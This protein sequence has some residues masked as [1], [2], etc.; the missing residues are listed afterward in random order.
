MTVPRI[1]LMLLTCVVAALACGGPGP[2]SS[3]EPGDQVECG[4]DL[5]CLQETSADCTPSVVIHSSEDILAGMD[6]SIETRITITGEEDGRCLVTIQTVSA[7]LEYTADRLHQMQESGYSAEDIESQRQGFIADIR[8]NSFNG[9][10]RFIPDD[11]S[12]S[13]QYWETHPI[14]DTYFAGKDCSGD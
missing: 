8:S 11:L 4:E 2:D 6:I 5:T 1:R 14:E 12:T 7:E 13:L 3:P 9:T 10:C